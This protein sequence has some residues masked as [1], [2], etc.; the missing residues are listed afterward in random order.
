MCDY[1]LEHMDNR[2]AVVGEE[3]ISVCF[4]SSI[5]RGF[6]AASDVTQYPTPEG[7]F[8]SVARRGTPVVCLRPGTELVFDR[9]VE[10][11]HALG[12]FPTKNMGETTAR[13]RQINPDRPHEHHDALEFPSG[14]IVLLTRL[15]AGQKARVLQIPAVEALA[16]AP[17]AAPAPVRVEIRESAPVQTD[18]VV[19]PAE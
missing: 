11:D 3:I 13:F 6:A 12:F 4:E 14:R 19:E 5:T 1:S 8:V 16:S 18:L 9:P 17:E 7:R 15:V 10:C 2:P